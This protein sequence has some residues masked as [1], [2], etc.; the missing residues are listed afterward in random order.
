MQ[1]MQ[2]VLTE[3]GMTFEMLLKQLFYH[4]IWTILQ[5]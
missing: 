3:A 4:W 5:R 1:N 2:A